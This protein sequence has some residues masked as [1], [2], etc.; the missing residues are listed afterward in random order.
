M[1]FE[2]RK[3]LQ[4]LET[5]TPVEPGVPAWQRESWADPDGFIAALAEAHVGRGAPLKSRGGRHYDFFHDLVVRHSTS[6]RVALRAYDRRGGWQALGYRELYDRGARRATEWAGQGVKAG[7]KVCLLYHVGGELLVSL[8]AALSLG[9][10]VSFL[11]P[12]GR[13]FIARRLAA[14]GPE[15]VAAEPH[16]VML[17]QGLEKLLLQSA[18]KGGP[19]FTS[20]TYKPAEPL[21]LLFSPLVEPPGTPAVLTAED[22][23]R[24]A[25]VDG[26]LT[27]GLGPGDHLA[28]PGYHPLQHALAFLFTALFRGATYLHLELP[29]L[30]A[31]PALLAEHPI[32][33]L[34]VT[35]ALR[36]VLARAEVPLK[37]VAHWFRNPEEPLDWQPWRAWAAASGLSAVPSSNVLVDPAAGGA[38]LGSPRRVRDLHTEAFPAPGRR[39][40]LHDVNHS[41][42]EAPGDLGVFTLLEPDERPPGYVVL[43]RSRDLYHYGGPRTARRDGRA[44]PAAEVAEVTQALPFCRG[45]TVVSAPTGGITGHYRQVLLVFTGAQ[46]P[47]AGA[48]LQEVRRHIELELGPEHLPDR[49]ELIPLYPHRVEEA[50]DDAWCQSQY[51]TGALHRK[52]R[53]PL[54]QALTA[55]RGLLL[56]KGGSV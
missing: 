45:A 49:V 31:N 33:A 24:G 17:L 29:D 19:A 32:R 5:G 10:C 6:D 53:E 54:F 2:V 20:H 15:H 1:P 38:V 23:W 21:G 47:Q 43:A 40:A 39:W 48:W 16:Q 27:F 30:E 51:L 25:L 9:A 3:I 52:E 41:G 8:A 44:Y 34:G 35:P 13:R 37:D 50:V 14:L 22:A 56:E 26:M 46:S 42:Q 12:L 11:P 7:A 4:Q 55:L 36:D 18:G 28:A